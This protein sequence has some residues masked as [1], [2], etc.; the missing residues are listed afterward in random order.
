MSSSYSIMILL[1]HENESVQYPHLAIKVLAK[2]F[3][4]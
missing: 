3:N 4:L 1:V 2:L